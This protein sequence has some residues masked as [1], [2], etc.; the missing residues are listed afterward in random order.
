M[1]LRDSPR[2][3]ENNIHSPSHSL[4]QT[5][6]SRESNVSYSGPPSSRS[7]PPPGQ[8]QQFYVGS[9]PQLAAWDGFAVA[10]SGKHASVISIGATACS[11]SVINT[12]G[13]RSRATTCWTAAAGSEED[14]GTEGGATI[15]GDR[16]R[17][18]LRDGRVPVSGPSTPDGGLNQWEEGP[19]SGLE[20]TPL[21]PLH[22]MREV[23]PVVAAAVAAAALRVQ[24]WAAAGPRPTSSSTLKGES[25]MH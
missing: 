22:R 7:L 15:E 2:A 21:S 19:A 24:E 8:Q 23:T 10:S 1:A 9:A 16:R 14:G 4:G 3:S 13:Q 18:M 17:P 11:P 6:S 12:A 25:G 5:P 20:G